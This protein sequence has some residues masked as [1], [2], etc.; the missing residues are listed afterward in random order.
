MGNT[1]T[2]H[3]DPGYFFVSLA[4]TLSLW[5]VTA[6][7]GYSDWSTRSEGARDFMIALQFGAIL[8]IYLL[9]LSQVFSALGQ[10]PSPPAPVG[11]LFVAAAL[12]SSTAA[13]FCIFTSSWRNIFQHVFLVMGGVY[14]GCMLELVTGFVSGCLQQLGDGAYTQVNRQA[15]SQGDSREARTQ[16]IRR[17]STN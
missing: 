15:V 6:A 2:R 13:A 8:P 11:A 5:I 17:V 14:A 16:N 4:I 12:A 3:F 7:F 10:H 9:A 1:S